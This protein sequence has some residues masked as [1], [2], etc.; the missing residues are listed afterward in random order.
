[1][2]KEIDPKEKVIITAV[3]D[4]RITY[5]K[6]T[7]VKDLPEA[8]QKKV[9]ERGFVEAYG[10]VYKPIVTNLDYKKKADVLERQAV[11]L[12]ETI[13]QLNKKIAELEK[14]AKAK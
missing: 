7:P 14:M 10:K 5:D 2:S 6:F 3:T 4:K 1:M 11:S 12:K 9:K 8:L 13:Q